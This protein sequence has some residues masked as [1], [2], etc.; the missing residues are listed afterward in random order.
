MPPLDLS[1]QKFGRLLA[2]TI[3]EPGPFPFR[4]WRCL[5][6]CGREHIVPQMQ[7]RSGHT[8][9]CGCLRSDT[10]AALRRTHALSGTPEYRA[11]DGIKY[12]CENI[13]GPRYADWG[14]RGI[15]VCERWRHDFLAFLADMG[16]RPT[17]SHQIDRIDNDGPY[18][19]ENCRWATRSEQ[20][21]NRRS[22]KKVTPS[23]ST[24]SRLS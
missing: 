10:I 23:E 24:S 5:C 20:C 21:R 7:L 3:H 14:G 22:S 15:I 18:S 9:S 8:R 12:R 16:P 19:P 1:G 13:N 17:P 6:D 4:S 11:W 2:L